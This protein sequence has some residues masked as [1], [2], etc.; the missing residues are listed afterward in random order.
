[1]LYLNN[2]SKIYKLFTGIFLIL[3]GIIVFYK[4]FKTFEF[5]L[6]LI[7]IAILIWGIFNVIKYKLISVIKSNQE[8]ILLQGVLNIVFAIIILI[9]LNFA[10]KLFILIF[11]LYFI[12]LSI[13]KFINGFKL[14]NYKIVGWE[15][16]L[17]T[18]LIELL[19]GL[20]LIIFPEIISIIL[21][22]LLISIGLLK[23]FDY[24]NIR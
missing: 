22:F 5:L 10:T 23:I 13:T 18:G 6:T 15:I 3:I 2:N 7:A 12:F 16:S 4:P 19:V 17:T 1:M 9:S 21:S 14:K 24:F 20:L 8:F 11:G